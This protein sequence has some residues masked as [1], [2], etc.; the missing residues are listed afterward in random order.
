VALTLER[1]EACRSDS[2]KVTAEEEAELLP[3]IPAWS[4]I[5]FDGVPRLQRVFRFKGWKEPVAFTIRVA[6]IADEEDHHPSILTEW[7]RVTVTW[8]TYTI[9]GLHRND[10]VMAAKTDE[11]FTNLHPN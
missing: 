6:A 5:E 10:F 8:L 4:L 7:N 2:P 3:Q 1:C 9:R 11:V